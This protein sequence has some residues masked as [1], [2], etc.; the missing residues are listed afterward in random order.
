MINKFYGFL[1]QYLSVVRRKL[2]LSQIRYIIG[3]VMIGLI[4]RYLIQQYGV[5]PLNGELTLAAF[6]YLSSIPLVRVG[7]DALHEV[8]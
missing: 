5:N 3:T 2:T 7:A 6:V 8:L 4:I 1:T